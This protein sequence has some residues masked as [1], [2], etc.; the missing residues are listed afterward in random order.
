MIFVC[1]V[2][3]VAGLLVPLVALICL[4]AE[5]PQGMPSCLLSSPFFQSNT[6]LLLLLLVIPEE[7]V[8]KSITYL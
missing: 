3:L 1:C 7:Q 2:L 5:S 4:K 8:Q 6:L